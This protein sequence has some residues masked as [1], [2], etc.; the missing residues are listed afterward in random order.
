MDKENSKIVI[1][2]HYEDEYGN[3]FDSSSK[4]DVFLNLGDT[5]LSIIGEKLNTFLRQC[6][7]YRKN[8]YILMEDLTDDEYCELEAYLS[9]LRKGQPE[10][11]T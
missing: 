7:Y 2:F 3:V 4:V 10:D 9:R 5:D 1:G 11:A 8:D 6:G